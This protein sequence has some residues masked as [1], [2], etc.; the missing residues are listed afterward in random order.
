PR[1][2]A[3]PARR[4][5]DRVDDF[6]LTLTKIDRAT[7]SQ[8]GRALARY[9]EGLNRSGRPQEAVGAYEEAV[10]LLEQAV[11]REGNLATCHDL[12]HAQDHLSTVLQA[13]VSQQAGVA[14]AQRAVKIWQRLYD[15]D[16]P[17]QWAFRLAGAR[18]KLAWSLLEAEREDEAADEFDEGL[19]LVA[20]SDARGTWGGR[21]VEAVLLRGRAVLNRRR[22]RLRS[23]L[24]DCLAATARLEG[25]GDGPMPLTALSSRQDC[26]RTLSGIYSDE[27]LH[28]FS[29]MAARKAHADALTLREAGISSEG[30]WAEALIHLASALF[31]YGDAPRAAYRA[32]QAVT[33]CRRLIA[34]GRTDLTA[35]ATRMLSLLGDARLQL[36]Q[37]PKA[38]VSLREAIADE[39]SV[40]LPQA[41]ADQSRRMAQAELRTAARKLQYVLAIDPDELSADYLRDPTQA[42][43]QLVER[44]QRW[45]RVRPRKVRA[46]LTEVRAELENST[47][48]SLQG[49]TDIASTVLGREAG[50]LAW[51]CK[52]HPSRACDELALE[53]NIALATMAG[54]VNRYPAG[55][56]ACRQALSTGTR[57][58]ET[59]DDD[60]IA[61]QV[62]TAHCLMVTNRAS[63]Y[64]YASA[65]LELARMRAFESGRPRP[66]RD[67]P[68][69]AFTADLLAEMQ[70][71]RGDGPP[72]KF[73]G[74][75]QPPL[76]DEPVPY[77]TW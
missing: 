29:M 77:E 34:D 15:A 17:G 31:R 53:L 4:S 67:A 60:H 27:P 72:S 1:S 76:F 3:R 8:L 69:S 24:T 19:R 7:A 42:L 52:A 28:H 68:D 70:A 22:G 62:I 25:Q 46:L 64:D 9:G 26:H 47:S 56:R 21:E 35:S 2:H 73:F 11:L 43:R 44:M 13:V 23:A 20:L 37:L 10:Q 5:P 18:E 39:A 58:L 30:H 75:S 41:T 61:R 48:I 66:L 14:A 54:Y 50:M 51:L 63:T 74:G 38:V 65:E 32:K 36:G 55:E 40:V 6:E 59:R 45:L 57:L 16:G 12:A 33:L 71:E 49:G